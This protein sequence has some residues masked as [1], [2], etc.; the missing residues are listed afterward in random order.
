M[1]ENP[2]QCGLSIDVLNPKTRTYEV[3][4]F[5]RCSDDYFEII[6]LI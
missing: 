2:E 4:T 1:P 3:M 6:S 5:Y